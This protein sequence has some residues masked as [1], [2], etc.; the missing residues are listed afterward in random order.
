MLFTHGLYGSPRPVERKPLVN[1]WHGDGPKDVRPDNGVGGADREHL[2]GRQ[3]AT[4]L[5]PPGCGVRRPGG[6]GPGHRKP[7]YR[8]ALAAG[9]CRARLAE[10]G[11]TGDFVVWMPTFRRTRAV[12]AMREQSETVGA[13]RDGREE[14]AALREG[15]GAR[16]IQLVIKPHPMDAEQHNHDGAVTIT[17]ADLLAQE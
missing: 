10:L 16:G 17:D 13:G 2:H 3:H 4:V 9:R 7:A 1:L 8:P 14:L 5:Q 6:P 12:G 11:I 15:L